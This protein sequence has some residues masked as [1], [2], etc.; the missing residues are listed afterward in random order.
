MKRMTLLVAVMIL[1]TGY[2]AAGAPL[3]A[4]LYC[5]LPAE[6]TDNPMP[7]YN[8]LASMINAKL[9][10][11]DINVVVEVCDKNGNGQKLYISS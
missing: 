1:M 5:W 3:K 9:K 2:I 8:R 4:M 7:E 6:D 11:A 10:A